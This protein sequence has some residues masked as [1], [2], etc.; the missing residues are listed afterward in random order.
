[1][2][3]KYDKIRRV[4]PITKTYNTIYRAFLC[5]KKFKLYLEQFCSEIQNYVLQRSKK[6]GTTNN[7]NNKLQPKKKHFAEEKRN[8]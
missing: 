1:M 7:N 4:E 6:I 2:I 3:I 8:Q 5:K